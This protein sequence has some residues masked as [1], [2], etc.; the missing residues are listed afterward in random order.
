[1]E[2]KTE[3]M[4][5]ITRELENGIRS[6]FESGAFDRYLKTMSRFHGYSPSNTVLIH[7]QN[8]SATL[9]QGYA[10]WKKKFHRQVKRG[11]KGIQILAP[12]PYT[13]TVET[14]VFDPNGC[15]VLD[16]DG[17]QAREEKE[18]TIPAFRPVTVFDVSQ[19]EGRPLPVLAQTLTGD[20]RQCGQLLKAVEGAASVPVSYEDLPFNMDGMYRL[21][22][23]RISVREGMSP[24]QTVCALVHELTHAR[25][26]GAEQK[27]AKD[28]RT[29][30]VEA[31]SVAF[32]V[33]SY[34]GIE[35][36]ENSF[37]YIAAWSRDRSLPE[38][39]KSL[40]T[41]SNTASDMIEKIETELTKI[42]EQELARPMGVVTD[43]LEACRRE[44]ERMNRKSA[45]REA[46]R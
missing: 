23:N 42:K 24:K 37:G 39:R 29:M 10:G 21:T 14:D 36:G 44:T 45:A 11:E 28:A 25:L 6:V 35:T 41:I 18:L 19:T 3:R 43:R 5:E 2:T 26:H 1:M 38:L 15:P 31:E 9:L 17:S 30:E 12:A 16:A 32:A 27:E 40:D 34:F 46:V 7:L 4:K 13:K 8:P 20:E 22:E 33:C